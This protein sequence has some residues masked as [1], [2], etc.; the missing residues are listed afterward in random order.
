MLE[1]FAR[2]PVLVLIIRPHPQLFSMLHAH[3]VQTQEQIDAYLARCD[4]MPNVIIDR[5]QSYLPVFAATDAIMS[6]ASS[7]VLEYAVT[8][9]PVLYLR[10]PCSPGL[11]LDGE[12]VA[13]YC[14]SAET[15]NEIRR[16][17]DNVSEGKDPGRDE[18]RSAI[19]EYMYDPPGNVGDA[20]KEAVTN[21]LTLETVAVRSR[22]ECEHAM[23]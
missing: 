8:G 12:F 14:Q 3:G 4:E 6:D 16:F 9:K 11:D 19:R 7:F 17:L 10:N 5:R 15:E 1:E 13:K 21:R 2:R 20:I 22:Q 18:R 23:N